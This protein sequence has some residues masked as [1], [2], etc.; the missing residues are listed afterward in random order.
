[1]KVVLLTDL[2]GTGKA[3]ELKEVAGGFARNYLIPKGHAMIATP[4]IIKMTLEQ[5]QAALVK[6]Q[7][8]SAELKQLAEQINGKTFVLKAKAGTE[9]KLFGS[10]TSA[11]IA[12]EIK[13]VSGVEIDKK[14]IELEKPIKQLGTHEVVLKIA[15]NAVSRIFV[16]IEA[17]GE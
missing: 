11:D 5:R 8:Y 13:R 14:K 16:N 10:V 9:Q 3:G 6:Q 4:D 7:K 12:E 1:M 15:K 2:T 17:V